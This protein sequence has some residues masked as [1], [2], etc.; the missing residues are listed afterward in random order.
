VE[1]LD[2]VAPGFGAARLVPEPGHVLRL[3]VSPC[4][5]AGAAKVGLAFD[6]EPAARPPATAL[7]VLRRFLR[8]I[9]RGVV[10]LSDTESMDIKVLLCTRA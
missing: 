10:A 9:G 7:V 5:T 1:L 6:S 2:H 4:S 3:I 8:E